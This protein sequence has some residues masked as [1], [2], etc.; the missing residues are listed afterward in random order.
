MFI[1]NHCY[2][3][4]GKCSDLGVCFSKTCCSYAV[5]SALHAFYE[6]DETTPLVSTSDPSFLFPSLI[7]YG[8]A[9]SECNISRKTV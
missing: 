3:L 9:S 2:L 1:M 7:D 6:E 8:Y 5:T 4:C